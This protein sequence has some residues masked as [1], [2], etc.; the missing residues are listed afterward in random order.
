MNEVLDRQIEQR[1]SACRYCVG[2]CGVIVDVDVQTGRA[3]DLRGD[4]NHPLTKG[5][6]CIKGLQGVYALN[7]PDRILRPLKRNE[8]GGFD[9]IPL[10]QA[11]DEIAAKMQ[12]G[13]SEDGPQS[14][15]V[16]KGTQ[17]FSH[18]PLLEMVRRWMDCI[19]SPY[20]FTTWTIDQSAK[21][22]AAERLG[23]WGADPH[24]M[25][26]S[27]VMMIVGGNP[28]VSI[29]MMGVT[30]T[31]VTKQF[32]A[33]K[34]RG[35]KLIVVDPRRSETAALADL[36]LQIKPGEDVTL[37]AGLLREV[38]AN[39][40]EDSEFCAAHVIQMEELRNAVAPFSIDMVSE[41]T[42]LSAEDVRAAARMFAHDARR[43]GVFSGTG[44][45]MAPHS[46]LSE[47]LLQVLNVVCGRYNRE[48]DVVR[49]AGLM[50]PRTMVA[51]V[52]PP[53]RSWE[54]EPKMRAT[55]Y[56]TLNGEMMT[57]ALPDEILTPGPGRVRS[58]IVVGGNPAAAFPDHL[59]T[60]K[61]L[62]AL[63]LLV[64][65]EPF[66][67]ET[68]RFAHYILPPTMQYERWDLLFGHEGESLNPE[69]YQQLLSAVATP[70]AG[71]DLIEDWRIFYE[72]AKRLGKELTFCG[73][74]MDMERTPTSEELL[75]KIIANGPLSLD[76]LK[77]HPRGTFIEVPPTV[78]QAGGGD[79]AARFEVAPIDVVEELEA[80]RVEH[81]AS[82]EYPYRLIS[83]RM[84][85]L[86][87]TVGLNF[88]VCRTREPYN[89]AYFHPQDMA[90]IGI[91][92]GDWIEIASDHGQLQ[93]IAKPDGTVGK[94]SISMTHC[95]GGLPEDGLPYTQ[96]GA[97]TNL[98]V[99]TDRN[100]EPINAMP[101][102]SAIPVKVRPISSPE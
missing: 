81:S 3:I 24:H 14:V 72:L 101:R 75:E 51:Q 61:A 74:P 85:E 43:G 77:K 78:V 39:G 12:I 67:T 57:A 56:G 36:H 84:R 88:P 53:K 44:P 79:P 22:V 90:A 29:G 62:K 26:E 73:S 55:G 97:N 60:L 37:F 30:P 10:E 45:S 50:R 89:P 63:D 6:A 59:K 38:L 76:H 66:M 32:K 93:A 28:L 70:P 71:S 35:M 69:P 48:G 18:A 2:N 64:T 52:Y 83:R 94:G 4:R 47:H 5:Y 98:L 82:K 96:V 87:N 54:R 25:L 99:S 86:L 41:R 91:K 21:F 13:I 68:A 17:G 34:E 95:W 46:N 58:L 31:N 65:I 33:A 42:G 19:G 100:V 8:E 1:Y 49:G 20:M 9:E 7:A 11:L 40:W 92:G 16:Y 27:D 102:M 15:A 23:V 80:V